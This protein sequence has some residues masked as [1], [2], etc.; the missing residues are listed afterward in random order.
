[1]DLTERESSLLDRVVLEAPCNYVCTF[2]RW[3]WKHNMP[4]RQKKL[5]ASQVQYPPINTFIT[6]RT[7]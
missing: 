1:M 3:T 6:F 2:T 5:F 4:P 7:N